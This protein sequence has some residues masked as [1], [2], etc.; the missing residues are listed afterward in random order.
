LAPSS[1]RDLPTHLPSHFISRSLV[2]VVVV[3]PASFVSVMLS[4]VQVLLPLVC[5]PRAALGTISRKG[6]SSDAPLP[7]EKFQQRTLNLMLE[8]DAPLPEEEFAAKE[9]DA[10]G[11]I[12]RNASAHAMQEAP[13]GA[14]SHP[15]VSMRRM[16]T[17]I[18]VGADGDIMQ[19]PHE[20]PP[21][22]NGLNRSADDGSQVGVAQEDASVTPLEPTPAPTPAPTAATNCS[23]VVCARFCPDGTTTPQLVGDDC[24]FCRPSPT[25]APTASPTVWTSTPAP[26]VSV[27]AVPLSFVGCYSSENAFG[28][29]TV[30]G[31]DGGSLTGGVN[32]SQSLGYPYVAIAKNSANGG[33]R[34]VFPNAPSTPDL[35]TAACDKGCDSGPGPCGCADGYNSCATNR[36]WA[37]WQIQAS[38][39]PSQR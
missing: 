35:G 26:T 18:Q 14:H 6:R 1:T 3:G 4:Y 28:K 32:A 21:H 20:T 22:A 17:Q 36:A 24:C 15:R 16:S 23:A 5:L 30:Y 10:E 37:V 38:P 12:I 31:G 8:S 2:V 7:E 11:K 34:W 9:F 33:H 13:M 27:S 25:P 29:D 39:T 19:F